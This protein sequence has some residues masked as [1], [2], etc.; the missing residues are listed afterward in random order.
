MQRL[1]TYNKV[2]FIVN[3]WLEIAFLSQKV[4]QMETKNIKLIG[5]DLEQKHIRRIYAALW[6]DFRN[7]SNALDSIKRVKENHKSQNLGKGTNAIHNC[8]A[9]LEHEIYELEHLMNIIDDFRTVAG[10][11]NE[12]EVTK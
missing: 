7:L 3:T 6:N 10:V 4:F 9:N 1:L 12:T 2:W 5:K 8:V 11:E